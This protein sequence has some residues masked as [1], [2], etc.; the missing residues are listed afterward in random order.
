[1][2][3]RLFA[4]LLSLVFPALALFG[5]VTEAASTAA[6][7]QGQLVEQGGNGGWFHTAMIN[8]SAGEVNRVRSGDFNNDNLDDLVVAGCET[9]CT[10]T[11]MVQDQ[12]GDLNHS[13]T[14]LYPSS[15]GEILV[16]D[17]NNDNLDDIANFRRGFMVNSVVVF[18]Q[19]SPLT[20]ISQTYPLFSGPNAI[21]AGDFNDDGRIDVAVSYFQTDYMSVLLQ[22]NA[23]NLL[24]P[25][26]YATFPRNFNDLTTGDFNNDG[27]TDIAQGNSGGLSEEPILVFIQNNNGTMNP[28]LGYH[29]DPNQLHTIS[30]ITAGDINGDGRDD[31]LV[32][33]SIGLSVFYQGDSGLPEVPDLYPSYANPSD[34]EIADI[35]LDGLNDVLTLGDGFT[36]MALFL[37]QESDN[38]LAPFELYPFGYGGS[39][40]QDALTIADINGDG[41]PDAA[42]ALRS[43]GFALL[44]HRLPP[45]FGLALDPATIFVHQLESP[46]SFTLSISAINDFSDTVSLSVSDMP[47]GTQHTLPSGPFTAPITIDFSVALSSNLPQSPDPYLFEITANSN[48]ITHTIT[49]EIY[50][51]N[52][53]YLPIIL[54]Q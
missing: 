5:L 17:L 39:F 23:G 50:L 6:V 45:D 27:L 22:D 37:Q 29:I 15:S 35:N 47:I 28:A 51:I 42:I 14:V 34:I 3:K 4:I 16:A 18:E 24:P 44:Y 53:T 41:R 31:L 2:K 10:L 33:S 13:G 8:T 49:A 52:E 19:I 38:T 21:A 12:N 9:T 32:Q 26:D 46:I 11:L 48:K 1:M 40:E 43:N 7:Q 30:S 36:S 25:V 54:K 20:F